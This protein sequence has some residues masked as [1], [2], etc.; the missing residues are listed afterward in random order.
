MSADVLAI[1]AHPDD[2]ELG[3][4]GTVR[5]LVEQGH[6]VAIVDLTEG[7]LGSRGSVAIRH[8]EAALAAEILGVE[9]RYN[10]EIPDGNI[11]NSKSNQLKLIRIVRRLRPHIVLIG[12]PECRHPDHADATNLCISALFYSGLR[13]VELAA[14]AEDASLEPWRPSHTLHYMQGLNFEP[15]LVVDVSPVWEDRIAAVRAYS[16][17]FHNPEYTPGDE[18]PETYISDPGFLTFVESR[19]RLLGYRIGAEFGEGFLYH[20]GPFGVDDLFATLAKERRV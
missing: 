7:E 11:E 4:G 18:E 14:N 10:L 12:A 5:K 20:Q 9:E 13:K 2:V 16:S 15:T 3:C 6:R 17:Q 8:R 1:G 19:A